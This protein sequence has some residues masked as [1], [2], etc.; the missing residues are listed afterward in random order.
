MIH[1]DV[2]LKRLR[3]DN[4]L[5]SDIWI[6]PSSVDLRL[7]NSFCSFPKDRNEDTIIDI[8]FEDELEA[9]YTTWFSNS[10]VME[11]GDFILASTQEYIKVPENCAAFVVGR[12][13][14][15]RIGIQVQNAGF[16]D[17][18]FEGEITLELQNQSNRYIRLCSGTRI[19]QVVFFDLT[20]TSETPYKG[21][22]QSQRGATFSRIFKDKE[23]INSYM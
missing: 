12:S 8:R 13:S 22:Y 19:C 18:G 16:I 14:I 21:K 5:P 9:E 3:D 6:G 2:D 23:F 15:G 1:S 17:P 11:P 7:S 4:F 10:L 20:K